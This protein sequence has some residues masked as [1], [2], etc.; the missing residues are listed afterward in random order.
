MAIL[1][2]KEPGKLGFIVTKR[3]GFVLFYKKEEEVNIG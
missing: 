3:V 1:I 2:T